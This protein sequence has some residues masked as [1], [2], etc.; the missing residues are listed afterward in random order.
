M[1]ALIGDLLYFTRNARILKQEKLTRVSCIARLMHEK[2]LVRLA[3]SWM[4]LLY[5]IAIIEI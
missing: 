5:G 4:F 1:T 2:S 3:A